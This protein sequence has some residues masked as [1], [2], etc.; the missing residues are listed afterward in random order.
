MLYL[1][2]DGP[3]PPRGS[4]MTRTTK[5]FN[6]STAAARARLKP[7]DKAY[8]RALDIGIRIG[9]RRH[10]LG[11]KWVWDRY[12]GDGHYTAQTI[13]GVVADDFLRC[14]GIRVLSFA[15]AVAKVRELAST[16][17]IGPLTVAE[18]MT[19]YFKRRRQKG[20][21]P[22]SD[23]RRSTMHIVPVLGDTPV[24][25]LTTARLDEWLASLVRGKTAEKRRASMASAN[26]TLTILRAALR[27]AA[28]TGLNSAGAWSSSPKAP[29][30]IWLGWRSKRWRQSRPQR[31]PLASR[32]PRRQ[33]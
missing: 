19:D 9:Y 15:Q 10:Q 24:D 27:G 31:R 21:R 23:E 12:L 25:S 7:R 32:P 3:C 18:A 8:F 17:P 5:D 14:D 16:P 4:A 29:P 6:L 11:G 28:R 26:R 1:P 13:K 22:D 2:D 30:I 20:G 33:R